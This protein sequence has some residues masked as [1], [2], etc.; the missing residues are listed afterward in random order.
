MRRDQ[1]FIGPIGHINCR[2]LTTIFEIPDIPEWPLRIGEVRAIVIRGAVKLLYPTFLHAQSLECLGGL[3]PFR[4][5]NAARQQQVALV[6]LSLVRWV[7]LGHQRN[8]DART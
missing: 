2:L 6:R 1:E 4:L 7:I 3:A 8:G 5:S